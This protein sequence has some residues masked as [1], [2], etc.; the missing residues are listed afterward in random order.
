VTALFAPHYIRA[1]PLVALL[2]PWVGLLTLTASLFWINRSRI[3][4]PSIPAVRQFTA[5]LLGF[6]IAA[7]L[8]LPVSRTLR[9]AVELQDDLFLY[10]FKAL[11]FGQFIFSLGGSYWGGCY[12]IGLATLLMA[13]LMA[14]NLT[15]APLVFAMTI[16]FSLLAIGLHLRRLGLEA[17]SGAGEEPSSDRRSPAAP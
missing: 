3:R 15:F 4:L 10:P 13:L 11:V 6:V 8:V 16:L 5:S 17:V 1:A 2:V 9:F 12:V 7:L 14:Y